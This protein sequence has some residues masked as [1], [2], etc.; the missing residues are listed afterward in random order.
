MAVW[1]VS[2]DTTILHT[3][4]SAPVCTACT[5][6]VYSKK[7]ERDVTTSAMA[8]AILSLKY[9]GIYSFIERDPSDFFQSEGRIRAVMY[10]PCVKC[11]CSEL[12][13]AKQLHIFFVLT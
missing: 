2:V 13:L 6:M 1:G 3:F 10:M 11:S 7:L 4:L 5:D 8:K 12:K 9:F